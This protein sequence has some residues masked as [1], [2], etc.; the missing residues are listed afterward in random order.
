MHKWFLE[1]RWMG[2]QVAIQSGSR[3]SGHK[4][5][6]HIRKAAG[7]MLQ[8]AGSKFRNEALMVGSIAFRWSHTAT[9]NGSCELATLQRTPTDVE[10]RNKV[11]KN[12][13][14]TV[15]IMMLRRTTISRLVPPYL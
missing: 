10:L 5:M 3:F 9:S 8:L 2:I 12:R 11:N 14:I 6:R 13:R 7:G 1:A 4:V 15:A